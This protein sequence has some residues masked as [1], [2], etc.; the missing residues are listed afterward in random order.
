M[1]ALSGR[2][3]F[4][5]TGWSQVRGNSPQLTVLGDGRMEMQGIE[6]RL[7]LNPYPNGVDDRLQAD[8]LFTNVEITAYFRRLSNEGPAY[9]GFT[10][11]ARGGPLG[12]GSAGGDDCDATTYYSRLRN[13]GSWQFQKELK[14][15]ASSVVATKN[16]FSNGLPLNTWIGIKYVVASKGNGVYLSAWIDTTEGLNG[17]TWT[18]LGEYTDTGNWLND[19]DYGSLNADGCQYSI[20]T[21]IT[22]GGGVVFIRNTNG[23]GEYKWVSVREIAEQ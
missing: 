17:G 16:V 2:D 20:D 1:R 7:Y 13:D 6:P 3:A 22:P 5:P 11:G 4:D 10:I 23:K 12:H 21:P 15:P 8:H 9:G 14:H 18:L 19:A